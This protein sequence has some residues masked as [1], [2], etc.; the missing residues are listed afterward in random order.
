MT[1]IPALNKPKNRSRTILIRVVWY[2]RIAVGLPAELPAEMPY[3]I[4]LSSK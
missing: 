3:K 4:A 2:N 1:P